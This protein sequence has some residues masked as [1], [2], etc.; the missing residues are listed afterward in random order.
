MILYK[1]NNS[2][3]VI[4]KKEYKIIIL[5]K[6]SNSKIHKLEIYKTAASNLIYR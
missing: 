1:K 5:I 6:N 2:I 3:E 4:I